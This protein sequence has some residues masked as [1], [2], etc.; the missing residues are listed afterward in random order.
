MSTGEKGEE[1]N[2][3]TV[4]GDRGISDSE[5][6]QAEDT[7]VHEESNLWCPDCGNNPC[8]WRLYYAM[9]ANHYYDRHSQRSDIYLEDEWL[10]DINR[11]HRYKLYDILHRMRAQRVRR[12]GRIP[13][14]KCVVQEVR[15]LFP[16]PEDDYVG[17][18]SNGFN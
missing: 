3:G 6:H 14:P 4:A 7:Q 10:A 8:E 13:F 11:E 1:G 15:L 12:S 5:N 16:D 2:P 17:F 9:A 18:R